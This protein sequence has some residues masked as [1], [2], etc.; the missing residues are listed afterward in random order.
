MRPFPPEE[1]EG[2]TAYA[3]AAP[4]EGGGKRTRQTL[5]DGLVT[6]N[7]PLGSAFF[8]AP[9]GTSGRTI[10]EGELYDEAGGGRARTTTFGRAASKLMNELMLNEGRTMEDTV[11]PNYFFG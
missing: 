3:A 4:P 9:W 5:P 2:L 8:G 6:R 10:G 7:C 1:G 11:I